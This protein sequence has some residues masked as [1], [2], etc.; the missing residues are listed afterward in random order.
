MKGGLVLLQVRKDEVEFLKKNG[1][2]HEVLAKTCHGKYFAVE[3]PAVLKMLD[4]YN[5]G[6][7]KN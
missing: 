6:R 5:N 1:L 3:S 7:I 2:A 4:R